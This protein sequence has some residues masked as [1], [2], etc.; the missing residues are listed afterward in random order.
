MTA[1]GLV[2]GSG[3]YLKDIADRLDTFTRE[4]FFYDGMW[5]EGSFS[6][7]SQ[8]LLG[9][10]RVLGL[11]SGN[12]RIENSSDSASEIF[13][14]VESR[15]RVANWAFDALR[16]PSGHSP[17]V[18]DTWSKTR[19]PAIHQSKPRLLGGLG[20]ALLAHGDGKRQVQAHLTWSGGYGHHHYDALSLIFFARGTEL[21][22]DIGYTH[23]R[24]RGWTMATASH[25]TVV[26]D[27]E[28]QIDG[29]DSASPGR[30][31]RLDTGH[32]HVQLVAAANPL[33]YREVV[34]R[35]ERMLVLI[36]AGPEP[37]YLIDIFRVVG[38]KQHD[39][40]LYGS[41]EVKQGCHVD[42]EAGCKRGG[43][44]PSLAPGEWEKPRSEADQFDIE[45]RGNAYQFFEVS[46][47]RPIEVASVE[48]VAFDAP[49]TRS[50]T[51]LVVEAGDELVTGVSPQVRPA[52]EREKDLDAHTR[53]FLMLRRQPGEAG[54]R[55]ISVIHAAG[56]TQPGAYS[57]TRLPAIG[58]GI[59]L[60]VSGKYFSDLVAIDAKNLRVEHEGRTL[61]AN[62]EFSV[63]RLATGDWFPYTTGQAS[64][65]A[66][67]AEAPPRSSS[68]LL[69]AEE[70]DGGGR[71]VFDSS[72]A[73]LVPKAGATLLM[74]Y[75]DGATNGYTI[76]RAA[77]AEGRLEIW[78]QEPPGFRVSAQNAEVRFESFPGTTHPGPPRAIW[79]LPA[80]TRGRP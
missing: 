48:T 80:S 31:L 21:I 59:A 71:F 15:A 17:P 23:T 66:L 49:A 8:V 25:N 57:A 42:G 75:G 67:A 1:A 33:A 3:E 73:T 78:T 55:F 41:A 34:E 43:K 70:R 45:E 68:Q 51:H 46:L 74:E 40:L 24:Q 50:I 28:N 7:Q 63:V 53:T 60:L 35:Y 4:Q 32:P 79:Q 5:K 12:D 14:R 65:G 6:Y 39:Y 64:Y 22:S 77:Q 16:M 44:A 54:S 13:A 10:N 52:K 58:S 76:V 69:R 38:G 61:I 47:R 18:H 27:L 9:I 19:G 37:S 36:D 62:G 2:L 30:L 56:N 20:H 11:I 26:V 29:F 72:Q